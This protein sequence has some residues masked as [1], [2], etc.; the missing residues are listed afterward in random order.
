M[1]ADKSAG[2]L[3]R[4]SGYARGDGLFHR[5]GPLQSNDHPGPTTPRIAAIN[6]NTINLPGGPLTITITGANTNFENGDTVTVPSG[7]LDVS[8]VVVNTPTSITATLTTNLT[9]VAG[10]QS[11]IVTTGGQNLTLP[12][13]IKVGAF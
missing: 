4:R 2:L 10:P 1:A 11:L 8:N 12:L 13:A 6:P 7:M 9:T 3:S 5:A